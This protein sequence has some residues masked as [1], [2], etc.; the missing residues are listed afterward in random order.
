MK[1]TV[2]GIDGMS[3]EE[4]VLSKHIE[5]VVDLMRSGTIPAEFETAAGKLQ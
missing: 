1:E 2:L 3:L 4:R 5:A